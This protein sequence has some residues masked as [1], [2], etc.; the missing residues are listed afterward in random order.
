M[1]QI[2]SG[3]L[4]PISAV[5][6]AKLPQ[7]GQR[8]TIEMDSTLRTPNWNPIEMQTTKRPACG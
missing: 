2:Q 1:L 5:V 6:Q 7:H 4:G 8:H 3:S